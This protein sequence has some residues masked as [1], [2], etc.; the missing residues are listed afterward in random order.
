MVHQHQ[1]VLSM[2]TRLPLAPALPAALVDQPG[3][4][5]FDQGR[6]PV[7]LK[8]ILALLMRRAALIGR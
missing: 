3:G 6:R 7:L 1:R 4:G 5:Q 8:Q 2:Y